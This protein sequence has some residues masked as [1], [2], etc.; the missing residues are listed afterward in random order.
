MR[1]EPA[2]LKVPRDTDSEIRDRRDHSLQV[3]LVECPG[4]TRRICFA[5]RLALAERGGVNTPEP[6]VRH[7]G[8]GTIQQHAVTNPARRLAHMD[9]L[10]AALKIGPLL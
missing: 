5:D 8:G 2:R 3:F 7:N 4:G 9:A 6:F 10:L 1:L